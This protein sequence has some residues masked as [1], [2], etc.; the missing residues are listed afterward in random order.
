[1]DRFSRLDPKLIH[2]YKKWL[3]V[4][5]VLEVV[6][7]EDVVRHE[8][9]EDLD[10]GA[11]RMRRRSGESSSGYGASNVQSRRMVL[12]LTG[13]EVGEQRGNGTGQEERIWTRVLQE[14]YQQK[15]QR[16]SRGFAKRAKG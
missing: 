12:I 14:Q 15:G 16:R 6:S 4:L 11:R 13:N 3:K 8:V 10:V 5:L 7:D 9:D 1:L 2:I